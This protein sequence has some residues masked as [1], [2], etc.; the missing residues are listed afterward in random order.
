LTAASLSNVGTTSG[1][2]HDHP[3]DR[4]TP[5]LVRGEW[6]DLDGAETA[7]R[8]PANIT[9]NPAATLDLIS[10]ATARPVPSAPIGAET[11]TSIWGGQQHHRVG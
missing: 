11:A 7:S 2:R 4:E 10:D 5:G 3:V 9:V 6:R 8:E 1:L